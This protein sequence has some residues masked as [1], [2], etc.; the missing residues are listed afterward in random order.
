M[1]A[2]SHIDSA[3]TEKPS[4]TEVS[5][6]ESASNKSAEPHFWRHPY[7][8]RLGAIVSK[9]IYRIDRVFGDIVAVVLGLGILG[10]WA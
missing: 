8:I 6:T 2:N 10:L 1:V 9:I 5:D 3:E 7:F 4:A